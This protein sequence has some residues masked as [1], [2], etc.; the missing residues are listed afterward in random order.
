[1]KYFCDKDFKE[2]NSNEEIDIP[3]EENNL[4]IELNEEEA[5]F[6]KGQTTKC[7][8]NLSP[9]KIVRNP[10]GTL[11][12]EAL[13]ALQYSRERRDMREQQQR[14]LIDS[15]PKD[16]GKYWDDPNADPGTRTLAA[17]L[18]SL[19]QQVNF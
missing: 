1:M 16:I 19:G 6:L 12:R 9:I 13:N 4:E 14:A 7:G 2:T 15:M 11:Q 18:K 3:Y 17:N 8:I 5:P 10:D